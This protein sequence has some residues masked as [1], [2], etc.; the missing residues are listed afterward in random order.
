MAIGRP[1]FLRWTEE[2]EAN[3][4][5]EWAELESDGHDNVFWLRERVPTPPRS[6]RRP[7]LLC[8]LRTIFGRP[9]RQMAGDDAWLNGLS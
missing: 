7:A 1:T 5:R 9:K 3:H 4:I 8:R 6:N 2:A